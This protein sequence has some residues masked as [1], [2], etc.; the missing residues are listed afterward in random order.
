[1]HVT[2]N[3]VSPSSLRLMLGERTG[4]VLAGT[5]DSAGYPLAL[6][7]LNVLPGPFRQN[8]PQESE[9]EAAIEFVEDVIMPLAKR[10]PAGAMLESGDPLALRIAALSSGAEKPK[11]VT[12]VAVEAL[13]GR[14]AIAAQRGAWIGE[15]MDGPMAAYLLILREIMHHWHID[16]LDLA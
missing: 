12:L 10:L 13:F 4:R 5:G 1:M 16:R 8:P 7:T 3:A 9:L 15:A 11:A 14:L 2:A 6:G